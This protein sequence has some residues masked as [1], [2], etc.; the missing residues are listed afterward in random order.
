ME[1]SENTDNKGQQRRY[2]SE[3]KRER[4]EEREEGIRGREKSVG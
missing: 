3:R 1:M 4:L 2:V